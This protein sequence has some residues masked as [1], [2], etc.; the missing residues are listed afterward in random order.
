MFYILQGKRKVKRATSKGKNNHVK[1]LVEFNTRQQG[2][3]HTQQISRIDPEMGIILVV[4][5]FIN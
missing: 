2:N 5:Y 1:I 4:S 3:Y